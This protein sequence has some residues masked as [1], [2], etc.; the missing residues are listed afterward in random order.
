MTLHNISHPMADQISVQDSTMHMCTPGASSEIAF[1]LK[2]RWVT[3]VIPFFRDF[4]EYSTGDTR[5]YGWVPN[6]M[7]DEFLKDC[8]TL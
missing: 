6:E 5:V 7:I 4:A 3:D 2:G 1:F 8:A